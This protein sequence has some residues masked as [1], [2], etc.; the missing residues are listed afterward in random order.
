M[1]NDIRLSLK[2]LLGFEVFR[3]LKI[4]RKI[5]KISENKFS[6]NSEMKKKKIQLIFLLKKRILQM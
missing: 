2:L 5:P 3:K 1:I 6:K 4:D